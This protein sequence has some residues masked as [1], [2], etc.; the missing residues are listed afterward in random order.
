MAIGQEEAR[1]VKRGV[2]EALGKTNT[3]DFIINK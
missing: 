3:V 1:L 2:R